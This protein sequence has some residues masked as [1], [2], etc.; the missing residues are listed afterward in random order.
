MSGVLSKEIKKESDE[1]VSSIVS[2]MLNSLVGSVVREANEEEDRCSICL[3]EFVLP[4]ELNCKHVFCQTCLQWWIEQQ[5][6]SELTCAMCR[7]PMVTFDGQAYLEVDWWEVKRIVGHLGYGHSKQYIVEWAGGSKT[8]EPSA[9]FAKDAQLVVQEYEREYLMA[10]RAKKR[11]RLTRKH[12]GQ[13]KDSL[14]PKP[15]PEPE[16]EPEGVGQPEAGLSGSVGIQAPLPAE[17]PTRIQ[18]RRAC[19]PRQ[20]YSEYD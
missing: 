17:T 7:T 20:D 8:I 18:P 16:V 1:E 10:M 9:N 5:E 12:M 3:Q 13:S 19:A 14:L 6:G 11:V 2:S 4:V 15:E